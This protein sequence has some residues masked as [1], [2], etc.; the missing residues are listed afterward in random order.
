MTTAEVLKTPR[1][2]VM[3]TYH[4]YGADDLTVNHDEL[5][6]SPDDLLDLLVAAYERGYHA[7]RAQAARDHWN[8]PAV[9]EPLREER[10]TSEIADMRARATQRH[11]E[12]HLPDGYDYKG[13]EVD[14]ETGMP[15]ESACA[16][17]RRRRLQ[18]AFDLAGGS[19]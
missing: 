18:H 13:G 19:R 5:C 4:D 1:P 9:Q 12:R 14:W 8:S 11:T 3:P 2:P 17:V 15:A 7:G 10:V 6:V 16:W